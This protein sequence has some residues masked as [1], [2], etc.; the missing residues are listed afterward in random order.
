MRSPRSLLRPLL[1][2]SVL[3]LPLTSVAQP[4]AEH[5]GGNPPPIHGHDH[6]DPG[7]PL[8]G[9]VGDPLAAPLPPHLH[10]LP[11]SEAQ[12]DKIFS[13]IHAQAP[14]LRELAKTARKSREE[15]HAL[16]RGA[17][18]DDGKAKALAEIGAKA[19]AESALI[20]ARLDQQTMKLLTPEQ[21]KQLDER[22]SPHPSP[23]P[24]R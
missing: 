24:A 1:V 20:L 3:A 21:R 14:K 18:F 11:L 10:G 7:M 16:A 12:Q 23:A 9:P 6:G 19:N 4:D 5:C 15:L 8:P 17:D 2:A 13:L 22:M